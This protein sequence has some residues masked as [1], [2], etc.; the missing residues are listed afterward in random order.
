LSEIKKQIDAQE[1]TL[2]GEIMPR[3]KQLRE[4]LSAVHPL[5]DQAALSDSS[6]ALQTQLD[7]LKTRIAEIEA[8]APIKQTG[9]LPESELSPQQWRQIQEVL[10]DKHFYK[11]KVDGKPGRPT[12]HYKWI[13]STRRAIFKWQ[14][15]LSEMQTGKLT[16]EQIKQLI[17]SVPAMR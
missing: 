15:A 4:G 16:P 3:I 5:C 12:R 9:K 1:A 8:Q 11:G 7:C 17:A 2:S 6:D 13:T 14:G 10:A